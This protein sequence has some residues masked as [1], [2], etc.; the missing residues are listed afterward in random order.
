MLIAALYAVS[1]VPGALI[2]PFMLIPSYYLNIRQYFAI[3]R[4]W[5]KGNRFQGAAEV[6]KMA[7]E[8]KARI[9]R[10]E[11]KIEVE[12]IKEK[13]IVKPPP[14]VVKRGVNPILQILKSEEIFLERS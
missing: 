1:L 2:F 13:L 11:E 4:Y 8:V 7:P 12:S 5:W 10:N 9:K 3:M 6:E 14:P